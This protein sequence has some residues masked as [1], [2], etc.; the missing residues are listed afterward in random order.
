[1]NNHLSSLTFSNEKGALA[2]SRNNIGFFQK[3][4]PQKPKGNIDEF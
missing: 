4:G 2:V 3:N 1:V